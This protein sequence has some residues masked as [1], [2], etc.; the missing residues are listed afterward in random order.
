M[1]YPYIH[2]NLFLALDS[3]S[4]ERNLV[5]SEHVFSQNFSRNSSSN[6]WQIWQ[7]WQMEIAPE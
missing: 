7:I 4:M 1:Q 3:G 2:M 6:G 5:S